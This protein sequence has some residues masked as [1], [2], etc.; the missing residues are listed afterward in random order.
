MLSDSLL[1]YIVLLL[2]QMNNEYAK[3]KLYSINK[4]NKINQFP[5]PQKKKAHKKPNKH[6]YSADKEMIKSSWIEEKTVIVVINSLHT[7]SLL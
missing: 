5:P 6:W 7:W 2:H 1:Q 3:F 4:K